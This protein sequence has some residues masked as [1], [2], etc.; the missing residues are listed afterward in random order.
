MSKIKDNLIDEQRLINE[1]LDYTYFK[2]KEEMD[3]LIQ[4][5]DIRQDIIKGIL[6]DLYELKK[7]YSIPDTEEIEDTKQID[8][9]DIMVGVSEEDKFE[10]DYINNN[11]QE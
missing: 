1:E 9:D 7:L 4:L 2:E 5:L 8:L 3:K 11:P 10:G 6:N